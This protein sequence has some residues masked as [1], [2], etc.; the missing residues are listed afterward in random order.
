MGKTF[1]AI[2]AAL[3]DVLFGRLTILALINLVLAGAVSGGAVFAA[4]HYLT[5]LVPHATG[6]LGFLFGAVRF[7]LGAGSIALGV[8]LSPAASMFVGGL[9]F[10]VAAQRVE[11]A[12]GA[13]P[14]RKVSLLDGFF[15]GL[16]MAI[17][18][19]LLNLLVS[20]LYVIP[21][22]NAAVFYALNGY[23]MGRDYAMIAAL[24]RM[25][26]KDALKLRRSA[27]TSVFL[28]GVAC[29]LIPFIG[30]LIG[31]SGMTRLVHALST[32]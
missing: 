11:K 13:P 22:I 6:W 28:V 10:D 9:L 2:G 17:P 7:L 29:A 24:R 21:G 30:P 26:F 25:P 12:I 14:V 16:R 1:Q 31:A 18:S 32:R 19:L 3:K 27:R 15:T 8:A 23:L 4:I 5:P 20:P